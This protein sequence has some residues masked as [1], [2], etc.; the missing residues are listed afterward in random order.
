[1]Q[2]I[3]FSSFLLIASIHSGFVSRLGEQ[4]NTGVVIQGHVVGV[5]GLTIAP[6]SL[7]FT[8]S[9]GKPLEISAL[10]GDYSI[11]LSPG[12]YTVTASAV[13]FCARS[14]E[15]SFGSGTSV[16]DFTLM[17]CSDCDLRNIDFDSAV[18]PDK[19][20]MELH[21]I[22]LTKFKYKK[23]SL[24]ALQLAKPAAEILFGEREEEEDLV[25]YKGL[26]CIG[27]QKPVIV[28]YGPITLSSE[29]LRFSKKRGTMKAEGHVVLIDEGQTKKGTVA[30][31]AI[32]GR[33]V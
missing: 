29:T 20:P 3:L 31:L 18:E 12:K 17:D 6:A 22:D 4:L 27:E 5:T 32:E 28:A 15:V 14:R 19:P 23:E 1:M 2:N 16:V 11:E 25:L 8:K 33:E 13:G 10:Y 24:D 21:N 9:D 26:P 7:V 30:E